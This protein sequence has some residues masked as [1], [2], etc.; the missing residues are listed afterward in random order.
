LGG[1][2]FGRQEKNQ[3]CKRGFSRANGKR[4]KSKPSEQPTGSKRSFN[5]NEIKNK[6]I[7]S[8]EFIGER[9]AARISEGLRKKGERQKGLG[10]SQHKKECKK[11]KKKWILFESKNGK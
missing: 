10:R 6:V 8:A 1:N 9:Q 5:D 7:R 11:K 2:P 3:C 4:K